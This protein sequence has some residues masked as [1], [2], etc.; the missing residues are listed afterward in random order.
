MWKHSVENQQLDKR[1]LQ[2]PIVIFAVELA[3]LVT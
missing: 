3:Q 2:F 1:R